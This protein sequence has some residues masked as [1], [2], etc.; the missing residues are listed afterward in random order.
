MSLV[1]F[2]EH[3]GDDSTVVFFYFL[4]KFLRKLK[5][6]MVDC[7][8]FMYICH[9]TC[10][11]LSQLLPS[12]LTPL[13]LVPFLKQSPSLCF[14][15]LLCL[16]LYPLFYPPTTTLSFHSYIHTH[17]HTLLFKSRFHIRETGLLSKFGL[18]Y[19]KLY[20]LVPFF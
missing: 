16:F 18:F 15:S 14:S 19:F 11:L 2:C 10:S 7:G 9:C 1:G 17:T 8:I 13:F 6:I 3:S 12:I 4:F 5:K 20:F